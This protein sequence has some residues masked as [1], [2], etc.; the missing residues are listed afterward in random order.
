MIL[1]VDPGTDCCG[2]ALWRNDGTLQAA[3]LVSAGNYEPGP[4]G[5]H[6]MAHAITYWTCEHAPS[7]SLTNLIIEMP[8]T[9]GGRAARGDTNDLIAL[10]ATVGAIEHMARA[11]LGIHVSNVRPSDWKGQIPKPKRAGDP[12]VV[13]TRVNAVL[14]SKEDHGVQW[15]TA[16]RLCWDVA[17]SIGIGL[18]HFK[19]A[20]K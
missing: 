3:A 13:E 1:T 6:S 10:G 9:Y 14:S 5:R 20:F 7:S 19:R 8:Q 15:P 18:W 4:N 17:D 16:R 11:I 2:V 12:Y